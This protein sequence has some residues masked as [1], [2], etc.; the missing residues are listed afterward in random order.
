MTERRDMTLV[1]NQLLLQDITRWHIV[2]TVTRQTVAD[3]TYGVIVIA[4]KVCSFLPKGL[5][6]PYPVLLEAISHDMGEVGFGDMPSRVGDL[7]E[8]E[9]K[10]RWW[11]TNPVLR[12]VK[13]A[14]MLE[15]AFALERLAPT[16][17]GKMIRQRMLK[18]CRLLLKIGLFTEAEIGES[19]EHYRIN[20]EVRDGVE[21][22]L[23]EEWDWSVG[24]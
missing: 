4:L 7:S 23:A 1:K 15:M 16:P 19:L 9:L 13:I 22:M 20:K 2:P 6:D 8:T 17:R 12:I 21:A 14:D 5:I 11:A 3:H 24:R 10:E 18:R